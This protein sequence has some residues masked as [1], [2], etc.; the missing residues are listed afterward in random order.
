MHSHKIVPCRIQ[1]PA[2]IV[3]RENNFELMPNH[4]P[5]LPP[6]SK[7]DGIKTLI[8]LLIEVF[9]LRVVSRGFDVVCAEKDVFVVGKVC[10]K[11]SYSLGG[12]GMVVAEV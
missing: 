3:L 7:R 4:P 9:F 11:G 5:K 12:H 6:L 2:S 10:R 8:N 1:Y